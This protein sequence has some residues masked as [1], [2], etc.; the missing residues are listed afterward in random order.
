MMKNMKEKNG[1]F[2]TTAS[3][4]TETEIALSQKLQREEVHYHSNIPI[5]EY[6]IFLFFIRHY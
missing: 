5:P 6:I 1:S 3:P 4:I 2:I